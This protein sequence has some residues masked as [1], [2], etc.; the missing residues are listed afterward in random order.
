MAIPLALGSSLALVAPERGATALRTRLADAVREIG[1]VAV[2]VAV[3]AA[4]LVV[5]V[6]MSASRSGAFSVVAAVV[7]FA[8]I[9]A[10]RAGR[11]VR[12]WGSP[13]S[14]SSR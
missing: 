12:L 2:W 3:A 13:A 14:G 7:A 6:L 9:G 4:V 5:G 1:G 11:R 10:P 8:A